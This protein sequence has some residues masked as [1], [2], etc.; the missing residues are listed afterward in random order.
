M[1]GCC[2]PG[3]WEWLL[4]T[5]AEL[6]CHR[7]FS[8]RTPKWLMQEVQSLNLAQFL[9]Q[10]DFLLEDRALAICDSHGDRKL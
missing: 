6:N 10:N 3:T 4:A 9:A 8:Q 5:A 2:A 7:Y 1:S